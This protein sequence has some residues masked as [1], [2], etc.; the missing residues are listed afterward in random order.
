MPASQRRRSRRLTQP[1]SSHPRSSQR[2]KAPVSP[3]HHLH[4]HLLSLHPPHPPLH[5]VAAIRRLSPSL[6]CHTACVVMSLPSYRRVEKKTGEQLERSSVMVGD[7][8]GRYLEVGMWT[9]ARTAG[10][11]AALRPGDIVLWWR[12]RVQRW[13]DVTTTTAGYNSM[14]SVLQRM[15]RQQQPDARAER[16]E[17]GN[18]SQD[19]SAAYLLP[20]S[21]P[22]WLQERVDALNQW[23]HTEQH[24]FLYLHPSTAAARPARS[25]P[26]S[27]VELPA[28]QLLSGSPPPSVLLNPSSLPAT[29]PSSL[30]SPSLPSALYRVAGFVTR[31]L[32]PSLPF[33][34]PHPFLAVSVCPPLSSLSSLVYRGC[35]HCLRELHPDASGIHRSVCE[36]CTALD[37]SRVG[38]SDEIAQDMTHFF[39]RPFLI[40]VTG[41]EEEGEREEDGRPEGEHERDGGV[42]LTVHHAV[43]LRL[44]ANLP[45]SLWVEER[46]L[47]HRPAAATRKSKRTRRSRGAEKEMPADEVVEEEEQDEAEAAVPFPCLGGQAVA[48]DESDRDPLVL[49]GVC[50][51][52]RCM[53]LS[54]LCSLVSAAGGDA[55][56]TVGCPLTLFVDVRVAVDDNDEVESRRL[57]L[58]G[59][60]LS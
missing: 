12:L 17:D 59:I 8:T 26:S 44:L 7:E 9:S 56:Q 4:K 46:P 20:F 33:F 13:K 51:H 25:S 15:Q 48:E 30:L 41:G 45:A 24:S 1:P 36:A 2:L 5:G 38:R 21:I 43:A 19:A 49:G 3:F 50:F 14:L 11:S 23:I 35:P 28:S 54:L 16:E 22:G 37:D 31:V 18:G 42:W 32:F 6:C 40:R 27:R 57:Q 10:W 47:R 29:S 58:V 60:Q 52:P 34:C 39:Y 55:L 53:W